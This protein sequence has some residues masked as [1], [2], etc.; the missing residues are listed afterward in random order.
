[1][2][3]KIFAIFCIT[4]YAKA[5]QPIS[6]ENEYFKINFVYAIN[7]INVNS[8]NSISMDYS[9]LNS[10][11]KIN[12][13]ENDCKI[14][15][16]LSD[17][18]NKYKSE[19]EKIIKYVLS[20]DFKGKTFD[21]LAEL[22]D[23]FGA[24]M[25]GSKELESSIEWLKKKSEEENLE[26]VHS[27]YFKAP[28]W[29]R[30]NESLY[31]VR[32]RRQKMSLLGLGSSVGTPNDGIWAEAFV[33]T[34]FQQLEDNPLKAK[35]KIVVY[36]PTWTSYSEMVKYRAHGASKAAKVGAIASLVS[37]VTPFSIYSPHTGWQMYDKTIHKIPTAS[38]TKEDAQMLQR[39]QDRGETCILHL[40]MGAQN[41]PEVTVRNLVSEVTGRD[42]PEE[43]VVVSGHLDSWDVGVGAMDDGG[44]S[45][46][47]W[48]AP[49]ILRKLELKPRR[50][51]RTVLFSGEEQGL[52]GGKAYFDLHSKSNE[53]FQIL[54]ESD[55][56]TFNPFGLSF[57]GNNEAQCLMKEVLSLFDSLN[58]TKL[59]MPMEGGPDI[60][61]WE[62][63]G[64]PTG[65]LLNSND[66]YFFYHHSEGD[67]MTVEDRESL[68][69]CTAF[70]T[71]LAYILGEFNVTIP[72]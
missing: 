19:V 70:W 18:I 68:D 65:A 53:K 57:S 13:N 62:K 23:T 3:I 40:H 43:V 28:H 9:G 31:L 55:S 56:G 1:M 4:S 42:I 66:D 15:P 38:I 72:R 64:I 26:N 30:N 29:V 8:T 48:L 11:T 58:T 14:S 46:I 50:T 63:A 2:I 51:I 17:E 24:R 69:K 37:S 47:S 10:T 54:L 67:T 32:P 44:G 16:E 27:E 52:H 59:V 25:T 45:I 33:V 71:A 21:L 41:F 12:S 36:N 22:T 5:I 35:G 7:D 20:G 6:E 39:F 34:N 61:F 60:I 49:V